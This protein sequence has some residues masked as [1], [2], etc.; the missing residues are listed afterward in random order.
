LRGFFDGVGVELGDWNEVIMLLYE[1]APLQEAITRTSKPVKL[2][3]NLPRLAWL[4]LTQ[5]D[6]DWPISVGLLN[7]A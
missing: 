4:S 7:S 1:V 2:V 3:E 6:Y 5:P